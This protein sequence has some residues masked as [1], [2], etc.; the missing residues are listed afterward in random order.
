[1][2]ERQTYTMTDEQLAKIME[3]SRP[4]P[5]LV[6]GGREPSSPQENANRAWETLGN[7]MGFIWDTVEP[8]DPNNAK[9]FTAIPK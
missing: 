6:F 4:V 9:T 2:N 7:E 3:A 5:Y 8:I 1:M